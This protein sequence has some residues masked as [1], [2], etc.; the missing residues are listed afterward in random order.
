MD[1]LLIFLKIIITFVE[2]LLYFRDCINWFY[3]ILI[4]TL[5]NM[6]IKW[7]KIG[8]VVRRILIPSGCPTNIIWKLIKIFQSSLSSREK[9]SIWNRSLEGTPC[10]HGDVQ[11]IFLCWYILWCASWVG[12]WIVFFWIMTQNT[13][14]GHYAVCLEPN[15]SHSQSSP[16]CSDKCAQ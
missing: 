14:R 16:N 13:R 1:Y 10:I 4:K 5:W 12:E 2:D 15:D 3:F 8:E 6:R 11:G 9:E 7:V